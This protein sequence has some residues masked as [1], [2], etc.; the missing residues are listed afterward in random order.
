MTPENRAL[1]LEHARKELPRESCGLLIVEKGHEVY[2]PCRNI[3]A[4]PDAFEIHPHDYAKAED[5]GAIIRVIHSHCYSS[6][7]PSE[8][9][10]VMCEATRVPWSIVS[11]PNGDWFEFEPSG[12][13]APLIGREWAH[14]LL[15]CYS[16]IRDYYAQEL[17]IQIPDFDREFEWWVKGGNL[18]IENYEKAGFRQIEMK[19]IRKNDVLIM[20]IMSPV[21]NHGAVYLGDDMM[22]HHLSKRLSCR[23][24]FGG[25]YKKHCVKVLRHEALW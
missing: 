17:G 10:K 5:R 18:Y 9:D 23:D 19:D 22:L 7:R 1:A 15:D 25:Y 13:R 16:I 21:P 24:I 20:Q 14:G 2:V 12:Y 8:V 3:S 4:F 6:P 11:V